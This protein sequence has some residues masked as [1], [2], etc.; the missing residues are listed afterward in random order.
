M[1][2]LLGWAPAILSQ[3]AHPLI[4]RGVAD[5]SS[6][7]TNP[8]ERWRR[9]GATLRAMLTLTFGTPEEG[10]RVVRGINAIHDRVHGALREPAAAFSAETTY[11]ARDPALLRW[12]HATLVDS[13]TRTYELCIGPLTPDERDR[14]CAEAVGIAPLLG[15]PD[16]YLP[17]SAAELQQYM[18]GMLESGELTVTDT[19]RVLARELVTPPLPRAARPLVSLM[20]LP[21]IGLLPAQIR[22]A[23]G[24]AWDSRRQ[25]TLLVSTTMLRALLRIAPPPLRY[26][27]VARAAFRRHRGSRRG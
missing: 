17:A 22:A 11:S 5:H 2:L 13:F 27:P 8:H 14:Y 7:L 4:A 16:D 12:V 25:R 21:T 15:I 3:F 24:F 18:V 26:W 10:A 19:A 6:F 1:A 20:R 9:L 23:Y